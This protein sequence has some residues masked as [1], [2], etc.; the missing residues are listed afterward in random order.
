M[1]ESWNDF[2]ADQCTERHYLLH[3]SRHERAAGDAG[4]QSPRT[5]FS[6][7]FCRLTK[8]GVALCDAGNGELYHSM[9]AKPSEG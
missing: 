4:V 8:E 2:R 5:L 7:F 6:P 3:I 9:S 1:A